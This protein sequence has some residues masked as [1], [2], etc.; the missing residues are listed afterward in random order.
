MDTNKII[1][2]ENVK[3]E[4]DKVFFMIL[5][6]MTSIELLPDDLAGVVKMDNFTFCIVRGY[7]DAYIRCII[8]RNSNI[9]YDEQYCFPHSHEILGEHCMDYTYHTLAEMFFASYLAEQL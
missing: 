5:N 1:Y 8:Y 3:F 2:P 7:T 6:H 9:A 4:D